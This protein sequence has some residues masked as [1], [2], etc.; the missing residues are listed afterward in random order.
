M[1]TGRRAFQGAN[2]VSIITAIMS[3][4][5][6]AIST[7]QTGSGSVVP[8][9]VERVV[10]RCLAKDPTARW[11]SARDLAEELKW[12]AEGGSQAGAAAPASAQPKSGGRL[13]WILAS[14]LVV[15][16]AALGVLTLGRKVDSPAVVRLTI[17]APAVNIATQGGFNVPTVSPDGSRVAFTGSD[18]KHN[19][20]IWVRPISSFQH[21][22]VPGTQGGVD[23]FWSPDGKQIGFIVN[24][25]LLTIGIAGTEPQTICD[26]SPNRGIFSNA[27]WSPAGVIIFGIGGTPLHRV[28]SQGGDPKPVTRLDTSRG[29]VA[30]LSPQFLPDGRH[31]LYLAVSQ[32]PE[33]SAIYVGSLDSPET[34]RVM[35]S[36]LGARFAE[37]GFLMYV[38][39]GTLVAHPFDWKSAR[40]TGE[41]VSLFE[42]VFAWNTSFL[43]ISS[44]SV[45]GDTLA[46]HPAKLP[47]TDLTWFDRRGSRVATIGE[48]A[49]YTNPALSPDQ[50]RI[51]VDKSDPEMSLRDIWLLDM[52]G[53]AL[54]FT[55]HPR[56][57]FN[58]VWSPDGTRIAFSSDRK[59]I[60][61]IYMKQ[62][63]GVG[64]EELI[65]SS[66]RQKSLEGWSPD[67]KLLLYASQSSVWGVPIEGDRKPFR[68][69][70]G[71]GSYSESKVSADGK[72]IA[73]RSPES[74]SEEIYVQGFP[75]QSSRWRISTSGGFEPSWRRDGKELYYTIGNRL[76]VVDVQAGSGGFKYGLPRVLFEAP[77]TPDTRRNRYV[78]AAD[79]Q[80][81][82]IV[83]SRQED[84]RPIHIVLNWRSALK[85]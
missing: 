12:I 48:P 68:I 36:G 78:P 81:F 43:P 62:V 37:S 45:S 24:R 23:P 9:A 54:R 8:S 82:L 70:T 17:E 65:V 30:H 32:Q 51:S 42:Q 29:E 5:P 10:R 75:G 73:Y 2:Q 26:L 84:S 31:F 58:S 40:L 38:R 6:P 53:G 72:W 14:A 28:S 34:K 74:G 59:G 64:E 71:P 16:L 7:L 4:E 20:Q 13:L 49:A 3:S 69:V 47:V 1:L 33:N 61:D 11:Q 19:S 25:K 44:F 85:H 76:M 46:Y 80:R 79:G 57:D 18:D 41:P 66:G 60:R 27:S 21:Q 22:V 35:E 56:D 55:F 83:T 77:F 15:A 52:R 63:N 67:G 50:Q 39:A